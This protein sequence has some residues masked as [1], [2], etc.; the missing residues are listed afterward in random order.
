MER[1]STRGTTVARE[2]TWAYEQIGEG[3]TE[4]VAVHGWQNDASAWRPFV[5]RLPLDRVRATIVDLP[6]C[7]ASEPTPTWERSTI[8]ELA[9]DLGTV[10]DQLGLA[11]PVLVGHSLGGGIGLA[12]ALRRPER[13]ARLV[14]AGPVST[15]GLDV[16]DDAAFAGLLD[17]TPEQRRALVRAA[18]HRSPGDDVLAALE[19]VTAAAHRH[20]VEGA[21]RSMR[22]FRVQ[23]ELAGLRPRALLVAGDRDRHGPID[24]HLATWAAMPRAGLQVF[25]DVGHVPF[26]EV[27]DAFAEVVLRFLG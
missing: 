14:L 11:A 13:L 6:G 7:G 27:P 16:V 22:T 18:F 10:L 19:R 15:T 23:D 4:L 3:P 25:H 8:D 26:W 2:V 21:A 17:P 1:I 5:D 12:L 20:H 24:H 9:T